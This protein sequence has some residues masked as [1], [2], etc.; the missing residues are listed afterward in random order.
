[1]ALVTNN[2]LMVPARR[3]GYA[4]GAFNTSNLEITAAVFQ[5][6]AEKR[7][8]V[9]L[10][11]SQSAIA[12]AGYD[13]IR[14][15]VDNL[16]READIPAS[17]H[18][19]HGTDMDI[20]KGC[21]EHGWTSLMIDGSHH[22]FDEN[23]AVTKA[24]VEMA[25][26]HGISVEAELGR[27]EGIED[28]IQV[29][30]RD[31]SMT[32]PEDAARFVELTG[33]DS[34]A[35]AIG[36]SHGAYKFKGDARLDIARLE[37]IAALVSI[38]LVLHGASAVPP[39]VLELAQRYGADLPGAKGVPAESIRASIPHGVAK[40]NIDTDLRLAFT[41]HVR[42]LLAESP[43]VFDPRK[44]LGAAR[45]GMAEV[46]KAKMDLFGSTGRA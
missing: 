13:N 11:T 33:V 31:A 14:C 4:V 37:K 16:S 8:P 9:I 42:Q 19:D 28:E 32:D 5:A 41:G 23:V 10:A 34:L 20:I 40:V 21:I 24:V 43:K 15:L 29:D 44:I 35:V 45:D 1:M 39:Q 27:L 2:D 18:L 36:T 3:D 38:P 46:I 25:H 30:S 26:P 6:A 7:S 12:Y 22:P 17:L